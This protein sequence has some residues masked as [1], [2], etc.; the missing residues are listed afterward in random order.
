MTSKIYN[1]K[2][3]N[4]K[5]TLAHITSQYWPAG[6]YHSTWSFPD[7]I[8]LCR[9]QR[10]SLKLL[11]WKEKKKKRW[12][13]HHLPGRQEGER[14]NVARTSQS[15]T[16]RH[17]PKCA[18]KREELW[19]PRV[20]LPSTSYSSSLDLFLFMSM[21]GMDKEFLAILKKQVVW[22]ASAGP[23]LRDFSKRK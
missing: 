23:R 4:T 21:N 8:G 11:W 18:R 9:H 3:L 14:E 12:L 17:F 1:L 5:I 22:R 13:W 19:G 2:Q 16:Q 10:V 15:P 6:K 20:S 7:R